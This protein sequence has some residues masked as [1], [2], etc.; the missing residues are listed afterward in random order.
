MQWNTLRTGAPHHGPFGGLSVSQFLVAAGNIGPLRDSN[1]DAQEWHSH[2]H[3]DLIEHLR[4]STNS[5]KPSTQGGRH[6][7]FYSGIAS[8]GANPL[9]SKAKRGKSKS[10]IGAD[11]YYEFYSLD[12]IPT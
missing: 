7:L 5:A 9:L 1:D 3:I 8:N 2:Y 10:Q 12:V 4:G 11:P 6:P